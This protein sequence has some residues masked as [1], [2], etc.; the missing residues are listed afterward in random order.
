MVCRRLYE[1]NGRIKCQST[2]RIEPK[3]PVYK[4]KLN[5]VI[6]V[7]EFRKYILNI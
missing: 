5:M 7:G 2:M 3:P 6:T 4:F 1:V